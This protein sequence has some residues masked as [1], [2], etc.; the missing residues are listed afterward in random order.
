MAQDALE[1]ENKI[2]NDKLVHGGENKGS[3]EA[4]AEHQDISP[5]KLRNWALQV[6]QH[7]ESALNA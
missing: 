6:F 7:H 3:V 1:G 5:W 2:G 4:P